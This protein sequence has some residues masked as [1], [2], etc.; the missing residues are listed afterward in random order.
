VTSSPPPAISVSR[1]ITVEFPEEDESIGEFTLHFFGPPPNVPPRPSSLPNS[2]DFET[3]YALDV[4]CYYLS[5]SEVSILAQTF[6]E[7]DDP[8]ATDVS[9]DVRY[10]N[11]CHV[12]LT[13]DSVPV[14]FLAS[15]LPPEETIEAQYL[16]V[17]N[18][19]V[20]DGIDMSRMA[21]SIREIR[22]KGLL[23]FE[24]SPEDYFQTHLMN[25]ALY[26]DLQGHS[27]SDVLTATRFFDVL[28]EWT[29]DQWIS[30]LKR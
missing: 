17:L 23:R 2:Q 25:E 8:V 29:S 7:I 19:L 21:V 16:A 11:P 4:M 27:L 18:S 9:F 10:Q 22:N 12:S 15:N 20:S 26:G 30:F 14:E 28:S 24:K 1:S 3:L 5:H 6:T 13:F